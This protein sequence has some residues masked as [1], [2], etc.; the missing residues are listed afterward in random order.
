[1]R[2]LFEIKPLTPADVADIMKCDVKTIL[3]WRH[4]RVIPQ[5]VNIG[6][7]RY[8]HPEVFFG[9]LDAKLKNDPAAA[10]RFISGKAPLCGETQDRQGLGDSERCEATSPRV[11][12]GAVAGFPGIACDNEGASLA[13]ALEV[14][15]EQGTASSS[16]VLQVE[17][18]VPDSARE[19]TDGA[20][21]EEKSVPQRKRARRSSS[22]ARARTSS[23]AL[24][25]VLNG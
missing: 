17:R 23:A 20:T 25:Q 22:V 14:E 19:S 5:P 13:V 16:Q 21:S 4:D 12:G 3:N 2:S 8:W 11:S 9:W 6:G 7:R 10:D 15:R 1:M 18:G 24:L